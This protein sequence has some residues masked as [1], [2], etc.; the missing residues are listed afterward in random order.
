MK[1]VSGNVTKRK[2]LCPSCKRIKVTRGKK[3]FQCCKQEWDIVTHLWKDSDAPR[4]S[5]RDK[6]LTE[7]E[8]EN[9][10]ARIAAIVEDSLH[11]INRVIYNGK[12]GSFELH[13]E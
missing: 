3:K 4:G 1:R 2:V 8:I 9:A 5:P 6:P 13:N 7:N 12:N 10:A 11:R